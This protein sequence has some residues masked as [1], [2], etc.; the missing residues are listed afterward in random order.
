MLTGI[1]IFLWAN[2]LDQILSRKEKKT[3]G[4]A[5]LAP[6][7]VFQLKIL[8]NENTVFPYNIQKKKIV[9]K[10]IFFSRNQQVENIFSVR[11]LF[12]EKSNTLLS[13]CLVLFLLMLSA[14]VFIDKS[15]VK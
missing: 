2:G 7:L 8:K 13:I 12:S 11:K 3:I 6:V 10:K 4:S 14:T 9:E 15:F 1:L 5:S